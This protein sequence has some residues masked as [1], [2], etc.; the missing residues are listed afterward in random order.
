LPNEYP[1]PT[2]RVCTTCPIG[3]S[4]CNSNGCL[5]CY[6]NYTFVNATLTCNKQCNTTAI[7]FY[8]SDCYTSCPDG[9]YLST[10]LVT[11]FSCAVQ[12]QTCLNVAAK[13]T[14]CAG[15]FLYLGQCLDACPSNYFVN[16]N[17]SCVSCLVVPSKCI[18][19]PL[20]YTITPFT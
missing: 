1:N 11:C 19:P 5:T 4:T 3:C 16:T 9:S 20:T 13:C 12:C 17:M 8:N 18:L 7:Y 10:D 2:T 15:K 14:R 6:A